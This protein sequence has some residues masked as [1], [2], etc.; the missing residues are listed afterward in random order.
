MAGGLQVFFGDDWSDALDS[1]KSAPGALGGVTL[2][3]LRQLRL[4]DALGFAAVLAGWLWLGAGIIAGG[5]PELLPTLIALLPTAAWL[6]A[7][8][9]GALVFEISGLGPRVLGYW[10]SYVIIALLALFGV[11]SL[12][13]ALNPRDLRVHRGAAAPAEDALI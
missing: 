1:I 13:L 9:I 12:R 8:I 5:N 4:V 3:F 10:E 11:V 6:V 2:S 7:G